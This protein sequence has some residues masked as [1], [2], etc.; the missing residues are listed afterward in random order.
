[1]TDSKQLFSPLA[2]AVSVHYHMAQKIHK[3][4]YTLP[5]NVAKLLLTNKGESASGSTHPQSKDGALATQLLACK[6]PSY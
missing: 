3:S 1:M 6:L 4:W 2:H 5:S